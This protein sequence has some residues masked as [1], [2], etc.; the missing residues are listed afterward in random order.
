MVNDLVKSVRDGETNPL[1]AYIQLKRIEL[2]V[3][4]ALKEI[5]DLAIDEANK[6]PEKR[7]TAYNAEVEKKSAASRWKYDHIPQWW[8]ASQK[9][10]TLEEMAKKAID[11]E[12]GTLVDEN[13]EVIPP[14]IKVEGKS[15]ISIKLKDEQN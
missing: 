4:E 1:Q 14:A 11:F 6:Y 5:S 8:S 3:S 12:G 7:F 10:K 15:I 2:E 9:L 13:G